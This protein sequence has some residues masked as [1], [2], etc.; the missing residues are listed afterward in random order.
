MKKWII[1]ALCVLVVIAIG[2][3][4]KHNQR[5]ADTFESNPMYNQLEIVKVGKHTITKPINSILQT[6]SIPHGLG[7]RP[8]IIAFMDNGIS[9]TILPYTLFVSS[10]VDPDEDG[11]I[12]ENVLAGASDTD[13]VINITVSY[14]G[15]G[16]NFSKYDQEV[17]RTIT[18]YLFREKAN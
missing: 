8:G 12:I 6:D 3:K 1:L 13:V 2:F 11:R 7:Y 15:G 10:S 9:F 14:L 16:G 18:Y 4:Q 17:S 5:M